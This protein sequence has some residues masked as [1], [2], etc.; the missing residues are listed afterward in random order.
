MLHTSRIKLEQR[1]KV[2]ENFSKSRRSPAVQQP[3]KNLSW[4]SRAVSDDGEDFG[5][6]PVQSIRRSQNRR[7]GPLSFLGFQWNHR[8]DVIHKF[9]RRFPLRVESLIEVIQWNERIG[10]AAD[11]VSPFL[12]KWENQFALFSFVYNI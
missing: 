3:L 10:A 1:R 11:V 12:E 4:S 2:V 5:A 9:F 7:V 8:N 6:G